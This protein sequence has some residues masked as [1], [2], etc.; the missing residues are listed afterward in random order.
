LQGGG[1]PG[2]TPVKGENS[3]GKEIVEK[4]KWIEEGRVGGR[5]ESE[6]AVK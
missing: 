5:W 6:V 1:R 4:E 2:G 3:R